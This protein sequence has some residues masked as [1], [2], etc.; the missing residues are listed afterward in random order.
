MRGVTLQEV[1]ASVTG[2]IDIRGILGLAKDVRNGYSNIRVRFR[3]KG[4]APPEKIREVVARAQSRS[5]VFDVV[6][7]GVPVTVEL[8]D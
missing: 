3:V 4:N 7:H 1:T 2:D 5:A 8:A 6:S